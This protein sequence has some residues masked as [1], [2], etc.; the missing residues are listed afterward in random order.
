MQ[1][2]VATK[3]IDRVILASGSPRRRELLERMGLRFEV[4][5][6]QVNEWEEADAPPAELVRH[7]AALKAE[8]A[9]VRKPQ[10][11]ILASDTTVALGDEVLNKPVDMDE[12]RTMLGRL[13]GKT[14]TVYTSIALRC[15]AHN[16]DELD[17]VTSDVT[18]RL[19]SAED[20]ERYIQVVN[21]LDKAGAY[22]IQEGKE[23]IIAGLDGSLTNV[24]GLPT[25]FLTDLF[26]RLGIWDSLSS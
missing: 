5:P 11:L 15:E 4:F 10:E 7:N 14:H 9:A 12:A 24:M 8:W 22:G 6:A 19:L 16:I 26:K 18:F 20:I 1:T 13:S 2:T 17:H 3:P 25:E 23:I 21:P